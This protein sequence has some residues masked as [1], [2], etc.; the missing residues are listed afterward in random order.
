M[1]RHSVGFDSIIGSSD[2]G[3]VIYVLSRYSPSLGSIFFSTN[4]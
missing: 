1:K 2:V 4:S 3:S